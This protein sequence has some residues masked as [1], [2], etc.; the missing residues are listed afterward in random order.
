MAFEGFDAGYAGSGLNSLG[1]AMISGF[2]NARKRQM[3]EAMFNRQLEKD[4][5]DEE[6]K[7]AQVEKLKSESNMLGQFAGMTLGDLVPAFK[8]TPQGKLPV[9]P[10]S[11]PSIAVQ[12]ANTAFSQ[13][14]QQQEAGK[15]TGEEAKQLSQGMEGSKQLSEL[16]TIWKREGIG[17]KSLAAGLVASNVPGQIG[18]SI[19]PAINKYNVSKSRFVETALRNATGAAAPPA[20]QKQYSELLP[21]AGDKPFRAAEK[22]DA[23]WRDM[24]GK[25]RMSINR[26]NAEG[27]TEAAKRIEKNLV[28]MQKQREQMLNDFGGPEF[29]KNKAVIDEL[30]TIEP[31]D[32]EYSNAQAEIIRL[33]GY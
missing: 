12:G 21:V 20:E 28:S 29:L 16:G 14:M 19:D 30:L 31:N 18:Q 8:D 26:L 4:A 11:A 13:K 6:Y 10:K 27:K 25:A 7:K 3:E 15:L 23:F 9:P 33:R 32:P 24:E 22:V 5:L 2:Q 1:T 17:N